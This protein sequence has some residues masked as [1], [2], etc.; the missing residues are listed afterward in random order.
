MA[1]RDSCWAKV[2][3]MPHF[4]EKLG[5]TVHMATEYLELGNRRTASILTDM[6]K[7]RILTAH[8]RSAAGNGYRRRYR[9]K[10]AAGGS[11]QRYTAWLLLPDGEFC[12]S[13]YW[14]GHGGKAP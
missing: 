11:G 13:G 5:F 12:V 14:S 7:A 2:K 10:C 6:V 9:A 3:E 1:E 4:V 8:T